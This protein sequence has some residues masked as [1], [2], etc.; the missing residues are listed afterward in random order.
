MLRVLFLVLISGLVSCGVFRQSGL[1]TLE[2]TQTDDYCGGA[3]PPEEILEEMRTPRPMP[4]QTIYISQVRKNSLIALNV[5]EGKATAELKPGKYEVRTHSPEDV[6]AFLL[7]FRVGEDMTQCYRDWM[8][9]VV[10]E[11]EIS[12]DL[13]MVKFNVH[14]TCDPCAPPPP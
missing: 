6:E 10:A 9:K 1:V 13:S 8:G 3:V 2:I 11:F 14:K 4:E 12:K 7:K 5:V